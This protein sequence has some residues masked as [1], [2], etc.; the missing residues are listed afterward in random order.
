MEP[1]GAWGYEGCGGSPRDMG[2]LER[3]GCGKGGPTLLVLESM[4]SSSSLSL[5][6]SVGVPPFLIGDLSR[7]LLA[8]AASLCWACRCC[9][10]C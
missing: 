8:S 10:C 1:G 2:S 7:A 6:L 5:A 9:W 3:Y 4:A